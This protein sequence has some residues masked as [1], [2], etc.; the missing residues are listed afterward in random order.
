MQKAKYHLDYH[1]E[2]NILYVVLTSMNKQMDVT[3]TSSPD[4]IR[5]IALNKCAFQMDAPLTEL[6]AASFTEGNVPS[7]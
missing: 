7:F 2:L 1:C 5:T 3:K 6:Y 4:S